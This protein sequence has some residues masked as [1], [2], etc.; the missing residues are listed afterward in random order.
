MVDSSGAQVYI[1]A[2]DMIAEDW[3]PTVALK[4]VRALLRLIKSSKGSWSIAFVSPRPRL[5][6][7]VP[8]Q[9]RKNAVKLSQYTQQRA[10]HR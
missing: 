3:S 7:C 8:D 9:W 10:G 6:L 4:I 1:D 5:A 2:V